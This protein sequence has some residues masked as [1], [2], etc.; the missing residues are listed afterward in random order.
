MARKVCVF[1]TVAVTVLAFIGW[2][3]VARENYETA[4]YKVVA[5]DGSFEVREYPELKLAV[6]S[7]STKKQ[8]NGG[9]MRLFGYI[10]GDNE[11]KQKIA[12]TTPVFMEQGEDAETG[13]MGFVLPVK[14]AEQGAPNPGQE[15]VS[16]ATRPPG[17]FAVYR[18]AGRSNKLL[19]TKAEQ[20]LREWIKQAELTAEGSAEFAGY[21]PPWT[22]GPMR[23][24]EVLIRLK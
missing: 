16:I 2:Q 7:M 23:R 18:F 14:V 21:D 12:M 24:N 4:E 17:K 6:T 9:F 22:P 1:L 3:A 5:A 20:K 19:R 10:S 11:S 8:E 15:N 13:R